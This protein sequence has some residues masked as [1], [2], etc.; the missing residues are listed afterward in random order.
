MTDE[1][2]TAPRY[3]HVAYPPVDGMKHIAG[4][5]WAG[6]DLQTVRYH[7]ARAFAF[8]RGILHVGPEAGPDVWPEAI[9]YFHAAYESA[10]TW[11]LL[12]NEDVNGPC[13]TPL[14]PSWIAAELSAE[15]ASPQNFAANLKTLM[16]LYDVDPTSF[17]PYDPPP[18]K[19]DPV[20]ALAVA[21]A[22]L[23]VRWAANDATNDDVRAAAA[24]FDQARR[25]G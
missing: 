18:R 24:L 7:L 11:H 3:A 23:L 5:R 9:P 1:T 2:P 10:M 25:H 19:Q 14:S 6:A 17:D 16:E 22:D 21:T 15:L 4:E 20:D 12:V 13:D 8:G